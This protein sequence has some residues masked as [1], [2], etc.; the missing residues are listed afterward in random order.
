M[1]CVLVP[2]ER[3]GRDKVLFSPVCIFNEICDVIL[4]GLAVLGQRNL[5]AA[6]IFIGIVLINILHFDTLLSLIYFVGK[7]AAVA[8]PIPNGYFD[9][10]LVAVQIVLIVLFIVMNRRDKNLVR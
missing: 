5:F 2:L 6:V 3:I 7:I 9:D 4:T 8:F 10:F 1:T